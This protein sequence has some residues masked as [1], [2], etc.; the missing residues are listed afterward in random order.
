M[1]GH[2]MKKYGFTLIELIVVIAIIAVILGLTSANLLGARGRARDAKAKAEMKELKNA[3][4]LYYND[5]NTYP[6]TNAAKP[7][8]MGCGTD[9]ATLCPAACASAEFA[10]WSVACNDTDA[11]IY[12]KRFPR[13]AAGTDYSFT[14][15]QT[16]A[17]DDFCLATPLENGADS[18]IAVSQTR[19]SA[20]CAAA[21]ANKYCVCAD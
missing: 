7:Y 19:C 18:E 11:T 10:S 8:I 2:H 15:A 16:N 21:C 17:G 13:N 12:M 3:L 6:A 14:Y 4:R 1:K 20:F 5:W 9:H